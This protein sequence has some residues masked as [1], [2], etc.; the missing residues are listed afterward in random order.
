MAET[1]IRIDDQTKGNLPEER[2]QFSLTG[3]N[4]NGTNSASVSH[5]SLVDVSSDQHH[6][7]LHQ[8]SHQS[9]GEDA[10]TGN[11]D[12]NAKVRVLKS[13]ASVGVRRGVNFIP[14]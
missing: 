12:A 7:K 3:H 11:L 6:P 13:G 4:H 1:K 14:G 9:G 8:S 10:L 5:N 2:I